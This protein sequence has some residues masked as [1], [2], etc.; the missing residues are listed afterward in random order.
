[1]KKSVMMSLV[2]YLESLNDASA[3]T[4]VDELNAELSKDQAKHDAQAK[5]YDEAKPIVMAEL[6]ETPV[7]IGELYEALADSLPDGFTK[8][9]LQYAVT[10]LWSAE[11]RKVEGKVNL[12]A[13]A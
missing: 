10:K 1:M 7:S 2:S 6:G 3:Q 13:K 11:L 4:F 12:Y 5:I 9:K 8:G